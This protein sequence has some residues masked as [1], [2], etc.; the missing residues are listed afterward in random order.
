[1]LKRQIY[2]QVSMLSSSNHDNQ[3]GQS[4]IK[5]VQSN[6]AMTRYSLLNN[7]LKNNRVLY[8]IY[9]KQELLKANWK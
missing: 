2:E 1:M 4:R 6:T 5:F 8:Y 7:F 9:E 3:P